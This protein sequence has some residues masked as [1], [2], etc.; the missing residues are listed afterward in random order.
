[1]LAPGTSTAANAATAMSSVVSAPL[2]TVVDES[3]A[4]PHRAETKTNMVA[5]ARPVLVDTEATLM[6][7]GPSPLGVAET[8][9]S[10][11]VVVRAKQLL[12]TEPAHTAA[13]AN[14]RGAVVVKMS[15]VVVARLEGMEATPTVKKQAAATAPTPPDA[16]QGLATAETSHMNG[17]R[18]GPDMVKVGGQVDMVVVMT[19]MIIRAMDARVLSMVVARVSRCLG[20]LGMMKRMRDSDVA[21]GTRVTPCGAGELR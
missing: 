12:D 8:K 9:M 16:R 6:E 17:S 21:M 3:Q 13:K 5:V 1:M 2:A 4:I 19:M 20:A 10:T 18:A 11:A 7:V 14:F 15:T